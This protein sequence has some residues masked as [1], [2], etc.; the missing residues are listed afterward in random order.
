V[1]RFTWT[2]GLVLLASLALFIFG[3]NRYAQF[4][5]SSASSDDI[6]DRYRLVCGAH[7]ELPLDINR[8]PTELRSLI[9]YAKQFGHSN[10]I[11]R[12]DC[13]TKLSVA[14]ARKFAIEFD[15]KRSEIDSWLQK[16]PLN[17]PANEVRA[18][19]ELLLF[20]Y[21]ITPAA[22]AIDRAA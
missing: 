2:V 19:R 11:L 21:E 15:S 14:D 9:P 16:F 18:F 6:A 17:F 4:D 3:M 20:R 12:K 8:I 7:G 1:R 13:A 22:T 5:L 10:S